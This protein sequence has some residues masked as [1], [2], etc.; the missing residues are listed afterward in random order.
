MKKIICLLT[1]AVFSVIGGQSQ[2]Q[3][4]KTET[5]SKVAAKDA[6]S[7]KA[8]YERALKHYGEWSDKYDD[9]AFWSNVVLKRVKDGKEFKLKGITDFEKKNFYFSNLQR[10]GNEMTSLDG[11]WAIEL[12]Q[13]KTTPLKHANAPTVEFLGKCIVNL[14]TLRKTS[15]VKLENYGEKFF[16]EFKDK[17]GDEEREQVM[18]QIREFHDANKLVERKNK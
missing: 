17:F 11:S 6:P 10:L 14:T 8:D 1:V 4:K 15:A 9:E 18:K 2:S 5:P 12:D 3:E 7:V 16:L 13:Y